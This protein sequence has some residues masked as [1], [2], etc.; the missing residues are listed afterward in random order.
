MHCNSDWHGIALWYLMNSRHC[1]EGE[2][3]RLS[4]QIA[5]GLKGGGVPEGCGEFT[6]RDNF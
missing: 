3:R 4:L 2:L 6:N 1:P 5:M